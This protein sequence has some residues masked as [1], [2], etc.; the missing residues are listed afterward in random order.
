MSG[1]SAGMY[2]S[3]NGNSVIRNPFKTMN[4]AQPPQ[5]N[6]TH[7]VVH[8]VPQEYRGLIKAGWILVAIAC[9][10]ALIPFFGFASWLIAGPVFLATFIMSIIAMTRGGTLPGIILLFTSMLV[11]PIFVA[12]AP[13]VSSLLGLAGAGAAISSREQSHQ[14]TASNRFETPQP[15][16]ASTPIGFATPQP[17][18]KQTQNFESK[19]SD[20]AATVPAQPNAQQLLVGTWRSSQSVSTFSS[21]GNLVIKFNNGETRTSRWSISGNILTERHPPFRGTVMEEYRIISISPSEFRLQGRGEW[22]GTR[23]R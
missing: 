3:R 1:A 14:A 17:R 15:R 21:D 16:L 11:G 9:A 8:H 23:I 5:S 12:C 20:F 6:P 7:V 2:G 10:V 18:P 22:R 13:F 19:G 4:D